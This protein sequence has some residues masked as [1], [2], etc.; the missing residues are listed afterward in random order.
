M[1]F[2]RC[3]AFG[4]DDVSDETV[5]HIDAPRVTR[6]QTVR[7]YQLEHRGGFDVIG[8]FG[9]VSDTPP[10]KMRHTHAV[11]LTAKGAGVM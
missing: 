2:A 1:R 8:G 11:C 6:R 9:Q 10:C 7:D 5:P 3:D 4:N